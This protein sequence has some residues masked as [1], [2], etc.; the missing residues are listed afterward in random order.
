MD[1]PLSA[2]KGSCSRGTGKRGTA[3]VFTF[4]SDLG[5]V[6][7]QRFTSAKQRGVPMNF[8]YMLVSIVALTALATGM[9]A[10]E[11]DAVSYDGRKITLQAL[12]QQGPVM[13]V[14]LRGFS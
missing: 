11:F 5:R 13:L 10:P 2:G 3:C 4:F 1:A 12:Q 14:F 8:Y 9:A 6:C 7:R